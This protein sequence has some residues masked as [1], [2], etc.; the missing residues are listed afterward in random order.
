MARWTRVIG[1]G[2]AYE[3]RCLVLHILLLP[4]G[5]NRY[6][7][8]YDGR[9]ATAGKKFARVRG[10]QTKTKHLPLGDGV[11]FDSGIYI[12]GNTSEEET[13]IVFEPLVG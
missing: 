7:D 3:G 1:D 8:V 2:L 4:S 5:N 12:N 11:P 9:D 10:D 6:A 13:T